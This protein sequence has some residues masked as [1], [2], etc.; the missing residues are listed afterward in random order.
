MKVIKLLAIATSLCLLFSGCGEKENGNKSGAIYGK[1]TDLFTGDSIANANVSLQP[2]GETALTGYDGMYEFINLAEGD[3]Y[4]MVSKAEY[5][6]DRSAIKVKNGKRIRRDFQLRKLP[7]DLLITDLN[8]NEIEV[9]DFGSEI[10]TVIRTFNVFNNGTVS[11]HCDISYS[12][13]WIK[14]VSSL[15]NTISP[16]QTVPVSVEINRELLT[17]SEN[18]TYLYITSNNGNNE[19]KIQATGQ[20]N[21]PVVLTLPVT[22]PDGTQGPY[23][24]TFHGNVTNVGYPPYSKRG[25][26]W[27]SHNNSPT[28]DDEHIEIPG[29]GL[30][31][32]SYTWWDCWDENPGT[33]VNYYVRTWVKYGTN[34]TIV[35]GNVQ[36]FIFNDF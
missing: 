30:G 7:V 10:S 8:G 29:N 4:I 31:E 33:P 13:V 18:A 32:Y 14:A 35:Y 12:C 22:M 24:N 25:F 1:V 34:N 3:Y 21:P 28:I 17:E 15:P 27:S 9:L 2:G 11:I 36:P 20:S 26:C 23:R 16:G 5:T 19:L 6:I